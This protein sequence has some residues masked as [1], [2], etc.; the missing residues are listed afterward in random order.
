M[1]I[2]TKGR[3]ALRMLVDLAERDRKEYVALKDI[4]DDQQISK[5]YLEQIVPILTRG[6]ILSTNRGYQGGYR[7]ARDP[8]TITCGEVLRLTEGSL[9]PIACLDNGVDMIECERKDQCMTLPV[10]IGLTKIINEYLDGITIRDIIDQHN[11]LGS[12]DYQI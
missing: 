4:A 9:S 12:N 7:L 8:S 2:S 1:K 3:Y 6:G 11:E 5:K 10:W